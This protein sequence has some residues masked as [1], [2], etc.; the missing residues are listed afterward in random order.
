LGKIAKEGKDFQAAL[1][2]FEKSLK[3]NELKI[4][5]LVERGTCYISLGDL[6]RAQ[7]E[8]ERII[9][10][11]AN[12]DST[13]VIHGRY[14]LA[15][16]YEQARRFDDALS[17][18]EKIQAKKP[19]FRDVPAKLAEYQDLRTDDHMKDYLTASD[20][21]FFAICKI[22]VESMGFSVQDGKAV[23]SGCEIIGNETLSKMRNT[24]KLPTI[25]RFLRLTEPIEEIRVR[26]FYETLKPNQVRKGIMVS[27]SAFSHGARDFA[28]NRPLDLL[29]KERLQKLLE[30]IKIA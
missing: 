4:K 23:D 29:D 8:L 6:S 22:M 3:D 26:N 15:Y 21:R 11:G 16:C 12:D 14:L 17:Q 20:D 30:Q 5:S 2:Y 13:E 27:S 10:L 7:S 1:N 28:E 24:K 9:K 19:N 25:F 18:W